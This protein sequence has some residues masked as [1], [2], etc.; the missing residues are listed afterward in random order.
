MQHKPWTHL[1]YKIKLFCILPLYGHKESETK[2]EWRILGIPV[3][4]VR[5]HHRWSKNVHYYLLGLIKV[6]KVSQKNK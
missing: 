3:W 1:N 4:T 2:R 5:R 6:M